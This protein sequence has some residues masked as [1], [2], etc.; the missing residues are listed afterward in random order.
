MHFREVI[1]LDWNE[2]RDVETP[3]GNVTVTACK[4]RHWGARMQYDAF[5][6]Y[7]AYVVERGGRR[8]GYLGDTARTDASALGARGPIDLLC[9]PIGT[10]YPWIHAHCS[11]EEAIAMADEANARFIVPLHH[12]TFK[13]SWEP[14]DEPIARFRAALAQQPERMALTEIGQT[15]TLPA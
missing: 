1:E 7:N 10:Y 8:L 3:R 2:T 12:Q 9:A 11:P 4:L 15:F 5:R 14:L 6:R 13:M